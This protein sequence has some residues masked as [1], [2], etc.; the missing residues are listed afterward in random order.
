MNPCPHS[1][2]LKGFSSEECPRKCL[3]SVLL[4]GKYC[5]QILQAS[6]WS[7]VAGIVEGTFSSV[8]DDLLDEASLTGESRSLSGVNARGAVV[9]STVI[10]SSGG[11][12]DPE[13]DP[14]CVGL[15]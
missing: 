15:W 3:Y 9:L 1:M 7:F 2:H 5:L 6:C 4:V 11:L 13:C 14:G 8:A 12:S 10:C